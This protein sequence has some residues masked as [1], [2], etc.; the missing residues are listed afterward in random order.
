[1]GKTL[2]THFENPMAVFFYEIHQKTLFKVKTYLMKSIYMLLWRVI[3][4]HLKLQLGFVLVLLSNWS[5]YFYF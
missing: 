1:M 2:W 4:N 3:E 5:V